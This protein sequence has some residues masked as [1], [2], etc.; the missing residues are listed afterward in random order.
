MQT[1][2]NKLKQVTCCAAS[3]KR[4]SHT[5][6]HSTPASMRLPYLQLGH[7]A[8]TRVLL[9]EVWSGGLEDR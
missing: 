8:L 5:M 7:R 4:R 2:P 6:Y 9:A 1:L 3:P